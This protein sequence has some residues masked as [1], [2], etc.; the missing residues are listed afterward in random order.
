MLE[1]DSPTL[2]GVEHVDMRCT[3]LRMATAIV[4]SVS[5][6]MDFSADVAER[7]LCGDHSSYT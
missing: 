7:H 5:S 4:D 1:D 6:P 2:F 3:P